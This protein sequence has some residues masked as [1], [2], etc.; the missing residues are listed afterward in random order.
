MN[1]VQ[2]IIDKGLV[3]LFI[4]QC[5][6][7]L[8]IKIFDMGCG[9]NEKYFGCIFEFFFIICLEG[10]GQGFGLFVVYIVIEN[11]KGKMVVNSKFGK[12]IVIEI[13]LLVLFEKQVELQ[14]DEN[15]LLVVFIQ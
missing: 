3:M 11:Y 5:G 10:Q 9:I 15:F 7:M 6:V 14:D 1:V 4:Q 8:Y 13:L 12:G 2:F